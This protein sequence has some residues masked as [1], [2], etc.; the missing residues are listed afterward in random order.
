MCQEGTFDSETYLLVVRSTLTN[1]IQGSVFEAR[2]PFCAERK[3]A[4]Y[5]A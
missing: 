1:R 4:T 3:A 2:N 5:F